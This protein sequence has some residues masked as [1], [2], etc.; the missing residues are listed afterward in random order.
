MPIKGLLFDFDGLILDTETV[1][2][3][4]WNDIY[5]KYG[6]E[7]N[8]KDYSLTIGTYEFGFSQPAEDLAKKIPTLNKKEIFDEWSQK[9]RELIEKQPILP[10]MHN[11]LIQA[12]KLKLRLGIASSA[13]RKWVHGHLKRLGIEDFFDSVTTIDDTGIPK[14]DPAIY[15]FAIRSLNLKPLE[16]LAFEDSPNGVTAAKAAG[17][18]C[19]AVPNPATISL[20]LSHADLV[21]KD[22]DMIPLE[23]LVAKFNNS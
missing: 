10:G 15:K 12:R 22:L 2:V 7:F 11:Y 8:F 9:E 13:P 19:I 6:L 18:H 20:D 1:D 16:I 5:E 21:I 17:I 4:V 14:P 23:N 3:I